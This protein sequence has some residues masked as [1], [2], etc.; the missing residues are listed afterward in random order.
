A[1]EEIQRLNIE[2]CRL[3][4]AIHDKDAQMTA[5]VNELLDSHPALCWEL[6][7]RWKL[8][9]AVNYVH[10]FR[11]DQIESQPGFSGI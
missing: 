3:Q 4:T 2:V 6:Q 11:L 7:N 1:H 8:H 9:S 5:T 10:L